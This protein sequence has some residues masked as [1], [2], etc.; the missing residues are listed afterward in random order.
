M[1][2]IIRRNY[3]GL[4]TFMAAVLSMRLSLTKANFSTSQQAHR[5]K[6]LIDYTIYIYSLQ[7][8]PRYIFRTYTYKYPQEYAV[9][10][11]V[12]RTEI[13]KDGNFFDDSLEEK[14]GGSKEVLG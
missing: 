10:N 1:A 4:F 5:G 2:R 3:N 11:I 14:L 6:E 7:G 13:S 9:K 12:R 8:D